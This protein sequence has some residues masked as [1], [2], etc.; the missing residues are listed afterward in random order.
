[1]IPDHRIREAFLAQFYASFRWVAAPKIH[2]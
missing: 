2:G 1:M